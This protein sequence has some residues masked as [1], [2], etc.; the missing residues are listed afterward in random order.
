MAFLV[1]EG[2]D[3]VLADFFEDAVDFLREFDG[4]ALADDGGGSDFFPAR[5]PG[6]DG[7][8]LD[9][10]GAEGF[11]VDEGESEEGAAEVSGCAAGVIESEDD[12][13]DLEGE[14]GDGE[15]AHPDGDDEEEEDPGVGCDLVEGG[16]DA[17]ESGGCADHGSPSGVVEH[18]GDEEEDGVEEG[19]GDATEEVVE[20]EGAAAHPAF[21]VGGEEDHAEHVAEEVA[22]IG[23]EKLEGEEAPDLEMLESFGDGKVA[24]EE[25][26]A[27]GRFPR[28]HDYPEEEDDDIGNDEE[29]GDGS[30]CEEGRALRPVVGSHVVA[31]FVAHGGGLSG[32]GQG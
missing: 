20:G 16:E 2:L 25:E 14:V 28:G 10:P 22:A 3:A 32:G 11:V 15:G 30:A 31:I 8:D 13:G 5:L 26:G 21:D 27:D 24:P 4:G 1:G 23:M 29:F 19:S 17:E 12:D 18:P 7:G 6:A 9:E